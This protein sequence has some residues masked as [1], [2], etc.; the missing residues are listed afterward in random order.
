MVR[1]V[2]G[3]LVYRETVEGEGP[4]SFAPYV[5]PRTGRNRLKKGDVDTRPVVTSGGLVDVR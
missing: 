1:T 4:S 2:E 5:P 3:S